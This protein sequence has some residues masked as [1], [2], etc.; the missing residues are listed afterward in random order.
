MNDKKRSRGRIWVGVSL[1]FFGFL[2]FLDKTQIIYFNL[3]FEIFSW[4]GIVLIIGLAVFFSSK[5]RIL[6]ILLSIVGIIFLFPSFWPL[7]IIALGIY[8]I[9]HK[10]RVIV[11]QTEGSQDEFLEEDPYR[12]ETMAIFG[13]GHRSYQITDFKGGRATAI[14]GGSEIDLRNCKIS[15]SGAEMEII[16]IFGGITFL[17]PNNWNVIV[18]VV[19]I[20]GGFHNSIIKSPVIEINSK[21]TIIIKGV[22]I[23][24]G[25]DVK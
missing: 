4:G 11:K 22:T 14:F 5:N 1:I 23:F 24:G 6:G 16:S 2:L 12:I 15:E 20:F 10:N 9:F 25:G 18:D 17:V 21:K 3:P 13:G 8:L 7:P 19:S